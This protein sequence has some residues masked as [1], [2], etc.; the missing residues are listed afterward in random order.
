MDGADALVGRACC[1]NS[2]KRKVIWKD[3]RISTSAPFQ[4]ILSKT[5]QF[6]RAAKGALMAIRGAIARAAQLEVRA[7]SRGPNRPLKKTRA[8]GRRLGAGHAQVFWPTL[9]SGQLPPFLSG[10]DHQNGICCCFISVVTKREWIGAWHCR[11]SVSDRLP[12]GLF[13]YFHFLP[14]HQ[15]CWHRTSRP[16]QNPTPT[17]QLPSQ[18]SNSPPMEK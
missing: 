16:A 15:P 10:R 11:A 3:L 2:R 5:T 13:I 9:L 17:T 7:S 1:L 14:V 12:L 18:A 4:E 6:F 8:Q